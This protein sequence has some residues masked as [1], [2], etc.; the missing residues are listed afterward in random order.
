M[1]LGVR[2]RT[3]GTLFWT[4]PPPSPRPGPCPWSACSGP[5][6]AYFD[7]DLTDIL[8]G[9]IWDTIGHNH[10]QLEDGLLHQ[11]PHGPGH[12]HGE[13]VLGH[14]SFV[15]TGILVNFVWW[16]MGCYWRWTPLPWPPRA[17]TYPTWPCFGPRGLHIEWDFG[18]FCYYVRKIS[19]IA[20][21]AA[22]T[23]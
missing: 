1:T 13:P 5:L 16:F 7:R 21:G 18:G 23:C 2:G 12:V 10:D 15:L 8:Y 6:K 9:D 4:P 22:G 3:W 17:G 20:G 19:C 14:G 11:D